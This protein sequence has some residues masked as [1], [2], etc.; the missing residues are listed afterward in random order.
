LAAAPNPSPPPAPAAVA[1]TTQAPSI[2]ATAPKGSAA[3]A[4]TASSYDSFL[5]P[6]ADLDL[7]PTLGGEEIPL[8]VD[9]ELDLD[10]P[11]RNVLGAAKPEI[12][13]SA[14][15]P[16]DER[17]ALLDELA[18][19]TEPILVE[20]AAAPEIPLSDE[21]IELLVDPGTELTEA[22]AE[23]EIEIEAD[24]RSELANVTELRPE[25][26][27]GGAAETELDRHLRLKQ[28]LFET[29]D[30]EFSKDDSGDAKG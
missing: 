5:A 7:D 19:R 1:A 20:E 28:S 17:P 2:R 30:T 22:A 23:P 27:R 21:E 14:E 26:E 3:A 6:G 13:V 10:T 15:A 29:S 18:D 11:P 9:L 24:L 8:D 4:V 25:E 16:T 12:D